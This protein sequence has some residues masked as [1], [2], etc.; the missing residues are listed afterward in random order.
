V[1]AVAQLLLGG[2]PG[3]L[4]RSKHAVRQRKRIPTAKRFH[5][6]RL[7]WRLDVTD[8]LRALP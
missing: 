8:P 1:Q 2:G 3:I 6:A 4:R 7:C 5:S